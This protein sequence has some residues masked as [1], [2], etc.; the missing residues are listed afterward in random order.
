MLL[1][2]RNSFA[3]M[4]QIIRQQER[5][6]N[7]LA[8]VN[9]PGYKK[10]RLFVEAL[11][12]RINEE[13]APDSMRRLNPFTDFTQGA[14][15]HTGNPLDLA[16]EGEGFFVLSDESGNTRYS[17]SST[18][19]L[20][21]EGYVQTPQ[22]LTLQGMGGPIQI[23][24]EAT[25]FQVTEDGAVV[26]NGQVIN[27][28]EI[29][30]FEEP[31]RLERLDSSSFTAS[32]QEPMEA[33]TARVKQGYTEASNVNPMQE[34]TDLLAYLRLFESQ[35]KIIQTQDQILGRITRELGKL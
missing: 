16:L 21:P 27:Q 31:Q 14:L 4:E 24:P 32:D 17:R 7:N 9:T 2:L 30:R 18:F 8:N 12:E 3:A 15:E 19:T 22:G 23:P 1:R 29:V 34:M 33:D 25:S 6:A 28:I 20:S 5:I 35:Q 11:Q 10:A 26:V 13:G